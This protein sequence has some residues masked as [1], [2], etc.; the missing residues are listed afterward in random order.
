MRALR[1]RWSTI[2][3][4]LV[5]TSVSACDSGP[6]GP[7]AITGRLSAEALGAVVLEVQ[8]KGIRG[9]EGLGASRVYSAPVAGRTDRDRVVIV[10]PTGGEI[11]F[12]IVVDDLGMNGPFVAVITAAG[13]D[14]L[15]MA[16]SVVDIRLVR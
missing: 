4:A 14:N 16:P 1:P 5:L 7:G 15:P 10:D 6:D 13:T 8:G 3:V 9:Y 2:V 12:R 11:Q